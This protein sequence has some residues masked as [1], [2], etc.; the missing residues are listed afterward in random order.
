MTLPMTFIAKLPGK[1]AG[2][3]M[4]SSLTVLVD[5]ATVSKYRPHL[6]VKGRQFIEG[7]KMENR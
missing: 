2:I 1:P 3:E 5:K 6:I 4:W 7:Q